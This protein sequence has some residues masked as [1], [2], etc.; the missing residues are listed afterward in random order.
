LR[1]FRLKENDFVDK[2]FRS[3]KHLPNPGCAF[4]P[5][6]R[7]QAIDRVA[8]FKL[9]IDI[10]IVGRS[11]PEESLDCALRSKDRIL[12]PGFVT[13][14]PSLV[15]EVKDRFSQLAR[16]E[17]GFHFSSPLKLVGWLFGGRGVAFAG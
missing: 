3:G 9:R 14:V 4:T 15:N 12:F 5:V 17:L 1:A 10:A 6:R 2:N 16:D 7:F 13:C 11:N 8:D